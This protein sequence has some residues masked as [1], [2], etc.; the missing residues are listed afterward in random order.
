M[1]SEFSAVYLGLAASLTLSL[2]F[3]ARSL[4][5]ARSGRLAFF[6][7]F[8]CL[9]AALAVAMEPRR[10]PHWLAL[11]VFTGGVAQCAAC[12]VQA[13]NAPWELG[14]AGVRICHRALSFGFLGLAVLHA[15]WA[16]SELGVGEAPLVALLLSVV[17]L[18]CG[19]YVG[20]LALARRHAARGAR[21]QTRLGHG[22]ALWSVACLVLPLLALMDAFPWVLAGI[23]VLLFPIG[24]PLIVRLL[25]GVG[26]EPLDLMI[27]DE[28]LGSGTAPRYAL[29]ISLC[30]VAFGAQAFVF[31]RHFGRCKGDLVLTPPPANWQTLKPTAEWD[32]RKL[33]PFVF[34][35]SHLNY[36]GYP[37]E[38]QDASLFDPRLCFGE[39]ISLR[40]WFEGEM[41]HSPSELRLRSEPQSGLFMVS[42]I[43]T[44][45]SERLLASFRRDLTP[46]RHFDSAFNAQASSVG[47]ALLAVG[48]AITVSLRLRSPASQNTARRL[49]TLAVLCLSFALFDAVMIEE[50]ASAAGTPQPGREIAEIP[51]WMI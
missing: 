21:G 37:A 13:W 6:A 14:P 25:V 10:D 4:G 11:L 16:L 48:V 23:T 7:A 36:K 27:Y 50:R 42:V 47:L 22:L 39:G 35:A 9:P 1:G 26:P 38:Y 19:P 33:G 28:P 3:R 20:G 45:E 43:D 12:A 24:L 40:A 18:L 17:A 49:S 46:S 5:L 34:R 29:L 41:Y 8:A 44:A 30:L 2:A 15:S 32:G 31:G 51:S